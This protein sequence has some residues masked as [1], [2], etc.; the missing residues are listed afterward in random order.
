MEIYSENS[1]RTQPSFSHITPF[2]I[3][4]V[5]WVLDQSKKNGIKRLYFVARDGKILLRIAEQLIN[6]TD[7]PPKLHYL[8]GS[9]KAWLI[10]SIELDKS[11]WFE[12]VIPSNS[13]RSTLGILSRLSLNTRDIS[14]ILSELGI[15]ETESRQNLSYSKSTEVIHKLLT[16][17]I[18]K[19]IISNH[20]NTERKLAIDYFKQEGLFD[21]TQW[22]IVDTGWVLHCQASLRRILS[23]TQHN[24]PQTNGFYIGFS[25]NR[26]PE[27]ETGKT[28]AFIPE[29][30]S[31]LSRRAAIIEHCFTP[32]DHP[33]TIGYKRNNSK[34]VPIF[35]DEYRAEY[36][37]A[38]AKKLIEAVTNYARIISDSN[39][40]SEHASEY[41]NTA[42]KV[43][44]KF[45]RYPSIQEISAF[46][47]IGIISDL[48][49][50]CKN[51][52]P[53]YRP[54][55]IIDIIKLIASQL[56]K[57]K[58]L[59][60]SVPMW[61]EASATISNTPIRIITTILIWFDNL[62]YMQDDSMDNKQ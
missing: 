33:T 1:K 35:D 7:S 24:T 47:S 39:S 52:Q 11:W 32:A 12:K 18:T 6:D 16:T 57:Y 46:E 22:A 50:N 14:L 37:I 45:I 55:K 25:K 38:Y 29:P 10:P 2:L 56:P 41:C 61:L 19:T 40:Y 53:L 48:D 13:S 49:H 34:V 28:F 4:Y 51:V 8:Y 59:Q 30:G 31:F 44:E 62:R 36:E 23:S 26:L 3:A 15:S 58:H 9:R 42:I 21:E 20:I 54:L 43:A 60:N 17:P 5:Q 27:H